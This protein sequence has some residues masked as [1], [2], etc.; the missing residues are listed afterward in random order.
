MFGNYLKYG[1]IILTAVLLDGQSLLAGDFFKG[2]FKNRSSIEGS[3]NIITE[4]RTLNS[5][6]EI[7]TSG[8]FELY[9]EVGKE[10]NLKITF[11][12]NLIDIIETRVRGKTLK[13]DNEESY[14][15][16]HPCKIDITVPSLEALALYGSGDVEIVNLNGDIFEGTIAGSGNLLIQGKVREVE[17]QISGSGEIDARSLI[18]EE[19]F[20]KISGSGDVKVFAEENFDGRVSGSG[21]IYYYGEPKSLSTNVSGSGRIKKR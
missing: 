1:L 5:F 13:I 10:P 9:I 11:D 21:S 6:N 8:A 7:V 16:D 3:G 17:L 19:A 4:T 14:S 2:L 20:V 18:A 15:S 12:D